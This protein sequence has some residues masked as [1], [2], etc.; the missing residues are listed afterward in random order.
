MKERSDKKLLERLLK[1]ERMMKDA[2]FKR[3]RSRLFAGVVIIVIVIL[4]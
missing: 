2:G 3:F 1:M 4:S